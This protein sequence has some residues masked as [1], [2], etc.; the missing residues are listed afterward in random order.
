MKKKYYKIFV[1]GVLLFANFSLLAQSNFDLKPLLHQ[2][3]SSNCDATN[4][5]GGFSDGIECN[6]ANGEI[7]ANDIL[8]PVDSD[9]T[10]NSIMANMAIE[11][12]ETIT[13]A[14]IWIFE[15]E[16]GYPYM[17]PGYEVTSQVVVPTSHTLLNNDSGMDFYEVLWDLT[18]I[19]LEGQSE[20]QTRYW[21]G[22]SATTSDGST[23]YWEVTDNDMIGRPS[24][25]STGSWFDIYNS[26]LDGS[27]IFSAECE[28]REGGGGGDPGGDPGEECDIALETDTDF[29]GDGI[30]CIFSGHNSTRY[31]A[32][33]LIVEQGTDKVLTAIKPSIILN[34][35]VGIDVVQIRVYKDNSGLPGE[36]INEQYVGITSMDLRTT[37]DDKEVYEV[38]IDMEPVFLRGFEDED[39]VYWVAIA[40]ATSDSSI[41]YWEVTYENSLGN[42]SALNTGANYSSPNPDQDGVYTF[43]ATCYDIDGNNGPNDGYCPF[44][45]VD[46]EQTQDNDCF[47]MVSDGGMFQSFTAAEVES[48]GVGIKFTDPSRG[49][50]VT[51]SLWDGL[52]TQ[53]GTMLASQTTQTYGEQWVDVFWDE[54]VELEVGTEYFIRVEGDD[55]LSCIRAA[56]DPYPGGQAYSRFQAYPDYDYTFRTYYCNDISCVQ[57]DWG[58]TG[59]DENSTLSSKDQDNLLATDITVPVGENFTID[60]LSVFVWVLPGANINDADIVFYQDDNGSPG[61]VMTIFENVEP[62]SE[63]INTRYGFDIYEVDFEIAP[64]FLSGEIDNISTY[65]VS[66]NIGT[67]LGSA[68]MS[69]GSSRIMGSESYNSPDNGITW[70]V[71]SGWETRYEFSG[72]CETIVH[73]PCELPDLAIDQ[74]AGTECITHAHT[75]AAQ[76]F[77]ATME[78]S[79]GAGI[80]FRAPSNSLNVTL[81]LWDNLPDQEGNMLATKTV[82]TVGENWVEVFWDQ[83]VP[84]EL[85]AVYFLVIDGDNGLPCLSGSLEDVYPGG[86]LYATDYEP[87]PDWDYTFRIYSCNVEEPVG[88]CEEENPNDFTFETGVAASPFSNYRAANDLTVAAGESFTL[89]QISASVISNLPIL[90]ADVYY[91]SDDSGFP[92]EEIASET[93]IPVTSQRLLGQRQT[94]NVYEIYL[95]VEPFLFEGQIDEP[96]TYWI[97]IQY[98]DLGRTTEVYWMVTSSTSI[99][100]PVASSELG[101]DWYNVNPDFDGVYTWIGECEDILSVCEQPDNLAVSD[102]TH[103]SVRVSWLPLGNETQ[104]Q[105]AYGPEGYN[106]PVNEAEIVLVN[107]TPTVVI[108]ELEADTAY[109]IYVRA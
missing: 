39:T 15:D 100:N 98:T 57:S 63:Y 21:V 81:S 7:A 101:G 84:L 48:S 58:Y 28:P 74:S 94:M 88:N 3:N 54:A 44:S 16:Y 12:G 109:D 30:N 13:S 18:P 34:A 36:E 96:T 9:L 77:T 26:S 76:S 56:L 38:L 78:A 72:L 50:E 45:F 79:A 92:G 55:E 42:P 41:P 47:G 51:L 37:F 73:N 64:L 25:Y 46:V 85:N 87:Y 23:A 35:G 1:I 60:K 33:D 43:Y 53:G 17:Y 4:P 22:I 20:Y 32:N 14:T 40:V 31:A 68:Y 8:V 99:G 86:H 95:D 102:I 70:E 91:Y 52:S 5:S 104:W 49:I 11:E 69:I 6:E 89:K 97:N 59:Y 61:E 93:G 19:V 106:D 66:L 83:I 105:V 24:A 27:Y 90:E 65:W 103:N 10:L 62:A 71:L 80:R 67:N 107:E 2:N 29:L 108:T 82:Q 75:G